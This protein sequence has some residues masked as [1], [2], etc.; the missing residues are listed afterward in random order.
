LLRLTYSSLTD[1][2]E[3]AKF[4]QKTGFFI[5]FSLYCE[6]FGRDNKSEKGMEKISNHLS[7]NRTL[8]LFLKLR[9]SVYSTN[10]FGCERG[11][12]IRS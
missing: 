1:N 6:L 11:S 2:I 8:I 5:I 4:T 7:G 9:P 3:Q 12:A 10:L